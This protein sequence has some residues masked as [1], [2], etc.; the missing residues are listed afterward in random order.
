MANSNYDPLLELN[1]NDKSK[2]GFDDLHILYNALYKESL[3]IRA[4][5][6]KMRRK[7]LKVKNL[8]DPLNVENVN[9]LDN[10]NILQTKKDDLFYKVKFLET[11]HNAITNKNKAF[12]TWNL[13]KWERIWLV[14][15]AFEKA[16]EGVP[17]VEASSSSS[18]FCFICNKF[19]YN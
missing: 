3:K 15:M 4:K 10:L 12:T 13:I 9:P 14:L 17:S 11:K 5:N 2:F 16:K 6:V 18:F 7:T 8:Y 1:Q 19:G